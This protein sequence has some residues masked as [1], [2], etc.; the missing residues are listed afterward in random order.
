[1]KQNLLVVAL[2]FV[3]SA[4]L[5]L[6]CSETKN[7]AGFE[8]PDKINAKGTIAGRIID[9]CTNMPVRGVKVSIA[10]NSTVV[11]TDAFGEFVF[12]NVPVNGLDTPG[13]SVNT[14]SYVVIMDFT[15]YNN[16]VNDPLLRYNSH[17]YVT[18]DLIFTDLNDGDNSGGGGDG[19]NG[20][21]TPVDQL[22]AN[23]ELL[24][25]KLNTTITGTVVD[26]NYVPV[27][28]A[29]VYL[30]KNLNYTGTWALIAQ[31][32]TNSSGAYTFNNVEAGMDV[33][34]EAMDAAR[35][36]SDD[37]DFSLTCNQNQD[38]RIQVVAEQLRL[39]YDDNINP[40]VSVISPINNQDI[41]PTG[42]AI[43]YTF[44]EP[45]KQTPYTRTDL[46]K[47]H[48]TI[49]DDIVVT[50]VG[51]KKVA[52][53]IPFTAAWN[54]TF[55]QLTITPAGLTQSARYT[56]NNFISIGAAKITDAAN[57]PVVNNAGVTGD[58][59]VLNFTTSGPTTAPAAPGLTR[60]TLTY[61]TNLVNWT[62]GNV[63]LR[64]TIDESAVT[65]KYFELYKKIGNGSFEF[66]ANIRRL[67]TVVT[68]N[69]N[70]LVYGDPVNPRLG[71]AVK[72]QIRAIST[73]L[74]PG[75]FSSEITVYDRVRPTLNQ[76]ALVNP[77]GSTTYDYIY[78]RFS[79]PLNRESAETTGNYS[80][81]NIGGS[82]P[83]NIRDVV[84]IGYDN[85]LPGGNGYK[86][87]ITVDD[88]SVVATEV[89]TVSNVTDVNGNT[90]DTNANSWTF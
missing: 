7:T 2:T 28:G 10:E 77:G 85:S 19:G 50:Y 76:A 38:L 26:M 14:G 82:N 57:N 31:T 22:V 45:I 55:T 21:D 40:F 64:W 89:L 67:D 9:R 16:S 71:Q 84:Y 20:Q 53:A 69:T 74:V 4:A 29:T 48:N 42:L 88:A 37:L 46:G 39:R 12:K 32:T 11:T 33:T 83:A 70:E 81:T 59:E 36:M 78:I 3:F 61:P 6:S 86:V 75:P 17:E 66:L 49:V 34:I 47:G 27:S 68:V 41:N 35:T 24:V 15:S 8:S 79:E 30:K 56:V 43:V 23:C 18:V 5:F 58:F 65:V 1:M 62:G 51:M 90:M 52:T 80:I 25:G 44:T 54:E 87:R 60:D 73:N 13:G 63:K 72:Y